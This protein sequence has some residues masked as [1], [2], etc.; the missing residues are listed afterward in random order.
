MRKPL[1]YEL[2]EIIMPPENEKM[3]RRKTVQRD[4]IRKVFLSKNR[5]IKV[6]EIL[7]EGRGLVESLNQATVYRN[8]KYLLESGWIRTVHHPELGNLYEMAQK[9]HHH[10]FHCRSCERV[11][12][13]PGCALNET[14]ST[15]PGFV[16]ERHEVFLFG[17]CSSCRGPD[18]GSP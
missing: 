14:K 10:H 8:L 7:E 13:L 1:H 15:P 2:D 11:F 5:A 4:A 9:E 12:D 18:A 6:E 17:V 16:A 3:T